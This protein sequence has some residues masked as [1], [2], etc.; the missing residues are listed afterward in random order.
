[1]AVKFVAPLP[2]ASCLM[3]GWGIFTVQH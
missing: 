1:M 2:P 3:F